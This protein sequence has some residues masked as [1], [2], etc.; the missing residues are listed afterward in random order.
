[1][2]SGSLNGNGGTD[3]HIGVF[4]FHFS[5]GPISIRSGSLLEAYVGALRLPINGQPQQITETD[6]F[7]SGIYV[8]DSGP[9]TQP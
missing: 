8:E 1:M 9:T 2:Y 4:H 5:L 6:I 7:Y 3:W